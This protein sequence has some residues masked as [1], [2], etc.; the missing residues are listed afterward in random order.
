MRTYLFAAL[1]VCSPFCLA[2]DKEELPEV[3]SLQAGMPKDVAA[4]ISR[5]VDC[6]HW[7]GEEPYDKER[8][9][10]IKNAVEKLRCGELES[11]EKRLNDK[12]R[13]KPRIL[14]A[15]KTSKEVSW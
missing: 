8:Q 13:N 9:E 3:K 7:G 14:N 6:N 2:D 4:F 12:Y 10:F 5:A 1:L 11:D 15:I